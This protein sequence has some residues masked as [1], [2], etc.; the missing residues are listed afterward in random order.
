M[1]RVHERVLVRLPTGK[2]YYYL[3]RELYSVAAL[4]DEDGT[5]VEAATYDTYGKVTV[6]DDSAQP[7][8]ASPAGNP[9][10]FTG[11]RLDLL[12]LAGGLKQVYHY[13]ARA[14]DPGNGRF[15]QRDP[16]DYADG[17]DLYEYVMSSPSLHSDAHGAAMS[18]QQC[19]E[20]A[21]N[22]FN[23]NETGKKIL[24]AIKA[25]PKC[26]APSLPTC[27]CCSSDG[28][29]E[30][31][32]KGK[33]IT[34]CENKLPTRGAAI[35]AAVHEL[36]HAYDDCKGTNWSSCSDRA[37]SEIR[38]IDLSGQCAIKGSYR[39]AH[40]SYRQ[41]VVKYATKSTEADPKCKPAQGT[42]ESVYNKCFADKSPT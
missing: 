37:C 2:E 27:S 4:T 26:S 16:F 17:A 24:A 25:D 3:P 19:E 7:V 5:I 28:W 35:E 29:G 10:Y 6:Y 1:S 40:E 13:R 34:L 23:S 36:V 33:S 31:D 15:M 20:A 14:Y 18:H 32:P 22:A 9:Y 21:R 30:F 38:A 11:R 41:C 12:P 8:D 39:Q 42:V